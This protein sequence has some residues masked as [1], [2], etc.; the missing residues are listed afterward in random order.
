LAAVIQKG[1]FRFSE[2]SPESFILSKKLSGFSF[3]T[4]LRN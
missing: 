2:D 1:N 3:F 4:W